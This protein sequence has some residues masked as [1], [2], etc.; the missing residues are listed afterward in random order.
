[1]NQV[2]A[3]VDPEIPG[4]GVFED[5]LVKIQQAAAEIERRRCLQ[6]VMAEQPIPEFGLPAEL[7]GLGTREQVAIARLVYT[8]VMRARYLTLDLIATGN[9]EGEYSR[10][11]KEA[12]NL[13]AVTAGNA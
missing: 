3:N 4:V 9:P 12:V 11:F 6:L 13:L 7:G 1:M 5:G 10:K 2:Q 8:E